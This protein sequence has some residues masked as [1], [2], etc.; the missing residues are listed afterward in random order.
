MKFPWL[1]STL[2]N[3]GPLLSV[4]LD[5]T[6]TDPRTAAEVTTRWTRLRAELSRA[7]APDDLLDTVE[8]AIR[9]PSAMGGPHG[10]AIIASAAEILVD[11]TLPVPPITECAQWARAPKLLP[12]IQLTPFAVSQLLVE[13][14]RAGADLTLCAPENPSLT[15]GSTDLG[16]DGSVDG[17][18]DEL[19]KAGLGGGSKHGWRSNNFEARVEDSWERNAEAVAATVTKLVSEHRPDM[20]LLT[21]DVRAQSLLKDALGQEVLSRLHIVPGGTRGVS[22]ERASFREEL[23]RITREFI[24]GRQRELGER[25]HESQARDA[26]SVAGAFEVVEALDRGQVDELVLVTGRE[27]DNVEDLIRRAIRTDA[28]ISALGDDYADIPEGVGALLRWKDAATPSNSAAS[29]SGDPG[30]EVEMNPLREEL[31]EDGTDYEKKLNAL[32]V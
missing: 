4:H 13:V 28:G 14:D 31:F 6:R 21:G 9:E 8:E 23:D 3:D 1:M 12:F 2:E 10:R 15:R 32:Q 22:L 30:R 27:P 29:M 24:E 16:D 17:G 20:V 26:E 11:R 7:G 18:H 5:T 19:H 25:F